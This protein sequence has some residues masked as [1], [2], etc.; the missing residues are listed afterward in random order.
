MTSK[1][2]PRRAILSRAKRRKRLWFSA[3]V[4]LYF[5]P[6]LLHAQTNTLHKITGRILEA[7]SCSVP[8]PCNF[9]QTPQPHAFCDSLAFFEFGEGELDHV[10]LRGLR[11]AIAERTRTR[12]VLY[13]DS[14]PS[15]RLIPV[16]RRIASWILSLDGT[17]LVAV[18]SA[19]VNVEFGQSK[20]SGWVVGTETSLTCVPL[21]GNDGKSAIIL[22][23]PWILGSF[24]VKSARKCKAERLHV[25]APGLSFDYEGTN[26]NDA[27]FEFSPEQVP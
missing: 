26:A 21:V 27:A 8:C 1:T 22:L 14:S 18:L 7:C 13:L 25:G 19:S 24:P 2:G 3:V 23:H 16:A 4:P 11:F 20:L 17:P 10:P 12:A 9:G 5:F 15:E 6:F